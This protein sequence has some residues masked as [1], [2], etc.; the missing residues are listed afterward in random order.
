MAFIT[1]AEMVRMPICSVKPNSIHKI[2]RQFS[3]WK[4]DNRHGGKSK[5]TY[6]RIFTATPIITLS[7]YGDTWTLPSLFNSYIEHMEAA[8]DRSW[9]MMIYREHITKKIFY[10]ASQYLSKAHTRHNQSNQKSKRVFEREARHR[11]QKFLT[12]RAIYGV[13]NVSHKLTAKCFMPL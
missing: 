3:N 5:F 4:N 12:A 7:F 13:S 11:L 8:H 1:H 2:P 6:C 10:C 9:K